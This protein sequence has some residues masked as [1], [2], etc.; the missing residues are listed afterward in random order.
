[1]KK[2]A[3]ITGG[4]GFLGRH[5]AKYL[6][7]KGWDIVV[8][9]D[10]STGL[11]PKKWPEHLKVPLTF[12]REDMRTYLE[13]HRKKYD[14]AI[15]LAAVVGGRAVIEGKPALGAHSLELDASFFRWAAKEKPSKI[16][17]MS[18]SAIYP[19]NLQG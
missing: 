17:F 6:H 3:L 14:L 7:K 9:D 12:I 5:F 11:H 8:V 13:G 16:V 1:M 15:H 10:L 4:C 2:K 18:S 19:V